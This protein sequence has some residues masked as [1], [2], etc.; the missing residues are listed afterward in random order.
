MPISVRSQMSA[1]LAPQDVYDEATIASFR[2]K[3]YWRDEKL[4]VAVDRLAV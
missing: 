2:A 3:G 4:S 1:P